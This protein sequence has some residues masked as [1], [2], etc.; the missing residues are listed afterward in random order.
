MKSFAYIPANSVK[1]AVS[2]LG[3]AR[4]KAKVMAGGTD[5]VGEMKAETISPEQIVSLKAVPNLNYVKVEPAGLHIG[6]LTPVSSLA[7][8]KV[9]KERYPLLAQTAEQIATPQLRNMGTVGGNLCQRPRCWYY[10]GASFP[11][12]KKGGEIC[13]AV[14]G[15]NLYHAILDGG[16]CYI[17]HPSDLAISL[18]ALDARVKVAGPKGE[19]TIPLEK[20]FVLPRVNAKKENI[21]G[22]DEILTEVQVPPLPATVRGS[23]VKFKERGAWDFGL[24]SAAALLDIRDGICRE[25]RIV[26]GSV[27]PVP[28]RALRAEQLL[29]GKRVNEALAAQ[30]GEMAVMA[31]RPM[32][33][34]A[35]KVKLAQVAVTR[36]VLSSA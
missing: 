30:A 36:A 23:Y 31:A 6:A 4:G 3:R 11:C 1:N 21:L 27:A 25:A 26:M 20:F 33:Q 14:D 24:V 17:V 12:L 29:R 32:A 16:P 10:R 15:E 8:H 19:R 34:N 18:V 2:L 5:L 35:Y 28:Y 7:E 13:Y 9:V 22:E